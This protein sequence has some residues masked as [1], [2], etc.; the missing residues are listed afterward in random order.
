MCIRIRVET[1]GYHHEVAPRPRWGTGVRDQKAEG[2]GQIEKGGTF[3]LF[4]LNLMLG[5]RGEH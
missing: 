5:M 2:R 4:V 3:L 1:H